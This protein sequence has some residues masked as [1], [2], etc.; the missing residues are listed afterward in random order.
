M[1]LNQFTAIAREHVPVMVTRISPTLHQDVVDMLMLI[2]GK[3]TSKTTDGS[4]P[5]L[6]TLDIRLSIS[7]SLS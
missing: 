2:Q 5:V 6:N 1:A 7:C 4:S 3:K